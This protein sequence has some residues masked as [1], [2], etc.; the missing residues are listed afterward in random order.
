MQKSAKKNRQEF[1]NSETACFDEL[2]FDMIV[3]DEAHNYKNISL[4]YRGDN[5]VGFHAVGSKKADNMLEKVQYIQKQRG[6]VIF[7][8]GTPIT[9]SLADL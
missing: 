2:G 5:I 8:T 3:V 7:A 9:N 1:I 6:R 4:E